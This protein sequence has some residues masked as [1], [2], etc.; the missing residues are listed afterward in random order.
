MIE[1]LSSYILRVCAL[2]VILAIST[3]LTI[4]AILAI[5]TIPAILIYARALFRFNKPSLWNSIAFANLIAF[6]NLII[7][8]TSMEMLVILS[9]FLG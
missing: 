8:I 6:T 2:I 1:A 4:L 5:P 9:P 7:F 3:V